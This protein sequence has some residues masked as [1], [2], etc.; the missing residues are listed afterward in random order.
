MYFYF[1]IS[2]TVVT[3]HIECKYLLK[4]LKILLSNF[5]LK[6][7]LYTKILIKSR[8]QIGFEPMQM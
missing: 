6:V 4:I 7:I 3:N 2:L 8:A 5:I 1:I